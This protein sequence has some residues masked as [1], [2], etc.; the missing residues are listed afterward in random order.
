MRRRRAF[1]KRSGVDKD[2][3]RLRSVELCEICDVNRV[4]RVACRLS[5]PFGSRSCRIRNGYRREENSSE[6]GSAN[7]EQYQDGNHYRQL[8]HRAAVRRSAEPIDGAKRA[9]QAGA[10]QFI[11]S[12][13]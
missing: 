1:A 5:S 4:S 8:D 9:R 3:S 6:I 10:H 11:P 13:I 12:I 2:H 7:Q